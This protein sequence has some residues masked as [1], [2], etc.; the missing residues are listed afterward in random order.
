MLV[1]ALVSKNFSVCI[2]LIPAAGLTSCLSSKT[3]LSLS[4]EIFI[5]GKDEG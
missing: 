1:F 3:A 2:M 5:L 4:N